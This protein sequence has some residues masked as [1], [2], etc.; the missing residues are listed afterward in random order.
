MGYIE[1]VRALLKKSDTTYLELLDLLIGLEREH[2]GRTVKIK[3]GVRSDIEELSQDMETIWKIG[4]IA[5]R[6]RRKIEKKLSE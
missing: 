1:D 3:L 5:N 4:K 2:A 6:L